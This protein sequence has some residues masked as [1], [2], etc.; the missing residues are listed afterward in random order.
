MH[1]LEQRSLVFLSLAGNDFADNAK[2]H[3][4]NLVERQTL[5]WRSDHA[6]KIIQYY[7]H[8]GWSNYC[9]DDC[10]ACYGS[11][12]SPEIHGDNKISYHGS[13]YA[14]LDFHDP[15]VSPHALLLSSQP[16]T[17]PP[18]GQGSHRVSEH[19]PCDS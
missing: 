2:L 9:G 7:L 16:H 17:M 4:N 8:P 6:E 12:T 13:I 15:S 11:G 14:A 19:S 5:C 18:A 3:V 1:I 10:L